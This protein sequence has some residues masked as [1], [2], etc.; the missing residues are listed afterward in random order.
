M[1]IKLLDRPVS[2]NVVLIGKTGTG[3]STFAN[4]LFDS[5]VFKT[6]LGR[7]G[8]DWDENFQNYDINFNG[9]K[10]NVFDSV[11][12][13]ENIIENWKKKF[14][15]F[16]ENKCNK[17]YD[18]VLMADELLHIILYVINASSGRAEDLIAFKELLCKYDIPVTIVLTNCDIA[19]RDKID[20]IKEVCVNNGFSDVIEVCSVKKTTRRGSTEP[21]GR[22]DA[23]HRIIDASAVKVGKELTLAMLDGV[24]D[25][26]YDIE[27]KVI[28]G[29]ED[30]D[31]SVFNLDALDNIDFDELMPEFGDLEVKD[32]VPNS[33]KGYVR[34]MD[35]IDATYDTTTVFDDVLTKVGNVL[36]SFD[37]EKMS[38][39]KEMEDK[40]N[41]LD[42][43][44]VS[45]FG[46]AW[47]LL[48]VGYKIIRIKTTIKEGIEEM[49]SHLRME[50]RNLKDNFEKENIWEE[51][52]KRQVNIVK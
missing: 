16:L 19:S 1:N 28:R 32:F 7:R 9:I 2:C 45:I 11:G 23:L 25:K 18:D 34:F 29:I 5:D 13:E 38:F 44:N 10:V 43:D 52:R 33:Y 27:T 22:E 20:G 35:S 6:S 42:D 46:K 15:E 49:F 26:F 37:V 21:F 8:T 17:A 12:L 39:A 4:Y 14:K 48:S 47:A 40:I 24:I 36:D 51:I 41:A 30:S 3:K 31:L 50:L